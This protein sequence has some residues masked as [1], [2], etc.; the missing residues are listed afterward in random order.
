MCYNIT[1]FHV[2]D[3]FDNLFLFFHVKRTSVY[4]IYKGFL[5]TMAMTIFNLCSYWLPDHAMPARISLIITTFLAN[6][7]ILQSVSD[8]TVK[9]SYTTAMQLFLLV[10]VIFLM[11]SILQYLVVVH[12]K[13]KSRKVEFIF[14][15][16]YIIVNTMQLVIP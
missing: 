7:F 1:F 10:N 12:L 11:T 4:Y 2:D 15:I 8:Q 9:V 16:R 13:K 5:P 6:T 3:N 14:I